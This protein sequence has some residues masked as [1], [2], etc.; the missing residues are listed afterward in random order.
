MASKSPSSIDDEIHFHQ[1]GDGSVPVLVYFICGNPGLIEYYRETLTT[2]FDS[3]CKYAPKLH[4]HVYGHSLPGFSLDNRTDSKKNTPYTLNEIIKLTER[5]LLKVIEDTTAHSKVT[6]HTPARVVLIGHSV[7]SYMLLEILRH[8]H[9]NV[10]YS[11]CDYD[12][13]AGICLFPTIIHIAASPRGLWI[14]VRSR[15]LKRVSETDDLDG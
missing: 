12:L 2:L 4:V 7:G 5:R 3:L 6:P 15:F 14:A 11:M 1:Q 9:E 8:R 10:L 13:I